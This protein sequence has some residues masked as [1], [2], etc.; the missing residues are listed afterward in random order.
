ML[1]YM[2]SM[3][4]QIEC[5][6][7]L[8]TQWW[9]VHYSNTIPRR[10]LNYWTGIRKRLQKWFYVWKFCLKTKDVRSSASLTSL[11]KNWEAVESQSVFGIGK[12]FWPKKNAQFGRQ[13]A[14]TVRPARVW[15]HTGEIKYIFLYILITSSDNPWKKLTQASSRFANLTTS[16]R[17]VCLP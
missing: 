9:W 3:L 10:K 6:Y 16:E 11:R 15:N 1:G 7:Y 8:S 4:S 17:A 14:C 12:Y 5:C 2:K 13:K